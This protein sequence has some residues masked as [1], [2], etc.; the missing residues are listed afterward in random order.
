MIHFLALQRFITDDFLI[1]RLSEFFSSSL[2][3]LLFLRTL[4]FNDFL[5][6]DCCRRLP[7]DVLI[8]ISRLPRRNWSFGVFADFISCSLHQATYFLFGF[9][10]EI[11][12]QF[13]ESGLIASFNEV[14]FSTSSI[15]LIPA[16]RAS[17]PIARAPLSRKDN[18]FWIISR[19]N[20][21][22]HGHAD[23]VNQQKLVEFHHP[24]R[25]PST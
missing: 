4:F 2:I 22:F 8:A 1:F 3:F 10:F 17:L 21:R 11:S 7:S 20:S 6:S 15:T 19:E 23:K 12:A 25:F 16:R 18:I 9:F 14:L 5:L 24:Y 13:P